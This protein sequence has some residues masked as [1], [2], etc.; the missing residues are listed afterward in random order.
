MANNQ[1][2]ASDNFASGSLAAGW[3]PIFGFSP[4]Q[5]VNHQTE[6]NALSTEAGQSWTGGS[7][8]DNDQSSEITIGSGYVAETSNIIGVVVRQQSGVNTCYQVQIVGGAGGG[9][10]L[11]KT[12]AGTSTQLTFANVTSAAGD[13]WVLQAAGAALTVYQNN[14]PIIQFYDTTVTG[15]TPGFLQFTTTNLAHNVVASWRGYSAVQQD[16]IWK[17]SGIVMAPIAADLPNGIQC[18]S[19]ILYEGNAQ[20]LSGTVYKTWFDN[21]NSVYYAESADGITWVRRAGA[22]LGPGVVN[23]AVYKVGS[24]YYLYIM[25]NSNSLGPIQ[26]YTSSDGVNFTLA[27]A[28]AIAL[29]SG[30]ESGNLAG[31]FA[32]I[33]VGGTRYGFYAACANLATS[34]FSIGLATSTDGVNWNKYAGNPIISNKGNFFGILASGGKYYAWLQGNQPQ[35]AAGAP[36]FDPAESVRY[37]STDLVTWAKDAHSVHNTQGFESLNQ[38]Q[39]YCCGGNIINIGGKAYNYLTVGIGDASGNV[40]GQTELAVAPAPIEQIV[41]KPEDAFEQVASDNFTSGVGD[42]NP[43]WVTPT[44]LTKLQIVPGNLCEPTVAATNCVMLYTGSSFSNDQYSEITIASMGA[45]PDYDIPVVRGQTNANSFYWVNITGP[46]GTASATCAV[47]KK[48]AGVST[49]IGPTAAQ[50]TPQVGDVFRLVASGSNPVLLTFYQNGFQIL[51]VEDWSNAFV[52]GLPGVFLFANTTLANS[53]I[54][55]WA[56][57]NANVIPNYQPFGGLNLVTT[58]KTWISSSSEIQTPILF[59]SRM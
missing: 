51:Q 29:T 24:T 25:Q 6:P 31:L 17:K 14:K 54:S 11:Y 19:P 41:T 10:F 39:G 30:W 33:V 36:F 2:L 42:L 43:N 27:N 53:Q 59:G 40:I 45:D 44:G 38:R 4:C 3:S 1:L 47:F 46:T 32:H 5:V 28:S 52:S 16:G 22:V 12:I 49:Q 56:G 58:D 48:V 20:L 8:F 35:G 26:V 50:I 34:N 23:S 55:S 57:G 7:L 18:H 9:A 21:F 13:V 15:G 37:V